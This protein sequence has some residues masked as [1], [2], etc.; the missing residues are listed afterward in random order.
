MTRSFIMDIDQ[1]GHWTLNGRTYAPAR[2]DAY[3]RL[4][5][6]EIWEFS[7]P[8]ARRHDMHLHGVHFQLLDTSNQPQVPLYRSGW[9][10]TIT[11][12][13]EGWGRILVRF[14]DHPGVYLFHCHMLEHGDHHMMAQ[15]EIVGPND[16]RSS[17]VSLNSPLVCPLPI[18]T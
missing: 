15:F 8:T 3:P 10:D 1:H 7:S 11:I 4:G 2:I 9:K 16:F 13:G 17:P 5:T 6:T 12:P 14:D 18:S